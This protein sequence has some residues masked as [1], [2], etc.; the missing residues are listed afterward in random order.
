MERQLQIMPEI[1]WTKFCGRYVKYKQQNRN[2]HANVALF[3]E[4]D[5]KSQQARIRPKNHGHDEWVPIR[6][7]RPWWTH[8]EDLRPQSA[9]PT[10]QP[11]QPTQQPMQPTP[12]PPQTAPQPPQTAQ[13]TTT[14]EAAPSENKP[15]REEVRPA[16]PLSTPNPPPFPPFSYSGKTNVRRLISLLD[17]AESAH[18]SMWEAQLLLQNYQR[19]W[20]SICLKLEGE[21]IQFRPHD[22]AAISKQATDAEPKPAKGRPGRK[23]GKAVK[24]ENRYRRN[25]EQGMIMD[26]TPTMAIRLGLDPRRVAIKSLYRAPQKHNPLQP[27]RETLAC[28]LEKALDRNEVPAVSLMDLQETHPGLSQVSLPL[29][30]STLSKRGYLRYSAREGVIRLW[31]A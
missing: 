1:D 12:Q 26:S 21:G 13:I 23:P 16:E 25:L 20:D 22:S 4:Y 6:H 10:P 17:E 14:S 11:M 5:E 29:A 2:A 24:D 30:L 3:K 27:V 28:L 15:A 7:V 18:H 19:Q 31:E 8:N 9:D